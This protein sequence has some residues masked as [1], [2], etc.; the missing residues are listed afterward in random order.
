MHGQ[1]GGFGLRDSG[2][3]LS[4]YCELVSMFGSR[5][6]VGS[7]VYSLICSLI[8]LMPSNFLGSMD[9][10]SFGAEGLG[11]GPRFDN[12]RVVPLWTLLQGKMHVIQLFL[13]GLPCWFGGI[14]AQELR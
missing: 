10:S 13:M 1:R 14:V 7:L 3:R 12:L 8:R 6:L 5:G 9:S 2:P 11:L 4:E